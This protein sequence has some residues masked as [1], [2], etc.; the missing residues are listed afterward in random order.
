MKRILVAGACLFLAGCG[1]GSS[2]RLSADEYRT[3]LAAIG[4]EAGHAQSDV[5]KGLHAKTLGELRDQLD[6]FA[7]EE[8]KIADEVDGLQAP[9]NAEHANHELAAGGHEIAADLHALLPK[10]AK[11]RSVKAALALLDHD[12]AAAAAGQKIDHALTKL[13]GLGYTA[14]S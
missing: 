6:K 14:G 4:K 9:K 2:D 3:Q 11:A 13:K 8:E 5:E 12:R 7:A 10:V 1:G